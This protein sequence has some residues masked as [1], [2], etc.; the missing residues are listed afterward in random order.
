[1]ALGLRY[2]TGAEVSKKSE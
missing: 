1:M 2:R